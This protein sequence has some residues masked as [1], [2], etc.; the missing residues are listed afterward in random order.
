MTCTYNFEVIT[1]IA[2]IRYKIIKSD[3]TTKLYEGYRDANGLI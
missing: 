1:G 3:D 2:V